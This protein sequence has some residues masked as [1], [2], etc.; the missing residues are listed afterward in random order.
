MELV[1]RPK[2]WQHGPY[3]P[4]NP[5]VP[6]CYGE[7]D[8]T[9]SKYCTDAAKRYGEG[10]EMLAFLGKRGRKTVQKVKTTAVEKYY[11]FERRTIFSAERGL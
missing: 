11:G 7:T 4:R 1:L 8:G 6:K 5:P 2:V 3:N 10:S 9:G